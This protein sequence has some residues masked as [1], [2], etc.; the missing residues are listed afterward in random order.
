MYGA[1]AVNVLLAAVAICVLKLET[2][3]EFLFLKNR[4]LMILLL[5][6]LLYR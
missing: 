5:D 1:A 4:N 6:K 2:L 3:V